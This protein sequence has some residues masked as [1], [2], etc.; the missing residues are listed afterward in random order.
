MWAD[1][2]DG[3]GATKLEEGRWLV[4]GGA[5]PADPEQVYTDVAEI[6]EE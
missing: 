1:H 4:A 3:P 2:G 6:L 5:L